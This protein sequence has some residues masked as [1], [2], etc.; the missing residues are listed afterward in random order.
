MHPFSFCTLTFLAKFFCR[1]TRVFPELF[2]AQVNLY[3]GQVL[4][5]I[6]VSVFVVHAQKF[7]TSGHMLHVWKLF[8]K[9]LPLID[10]PRLWHVLL[11]FD[12]INVFKRHSP[13]HLLLKGLSENC[14]WFFCFNYIEKG[15]MKFLLRC[16][17][18]YNLF[19]QSIFLPSKRGKNLRIL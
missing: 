6:L 8:A 17:E 4:F 5:D 9:W 2:Y 15:W 12:K 16:F 10:L 19:M 11:H 13:C 14:S 3:E 1:F 18:D 7:F